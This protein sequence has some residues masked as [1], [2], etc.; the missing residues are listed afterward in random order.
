MKRP[1]SL[2]GEQDR[3]HRRQNAKNNNTKYEMCVHG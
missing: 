2:K 3:T 1:I